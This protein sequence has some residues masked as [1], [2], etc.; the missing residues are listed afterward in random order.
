MLADKALDIAESKAVVGN[1]DRQLVRTVLGKCGTAFHT[2]IVITVYY[3]ILLLSSSSY[4]W[5]QYFHFKEFYFSKKG[6]LDQPPY[7]TCRMC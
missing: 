7:H 6:G 1:P 4:C 2:E 5:A 3:T